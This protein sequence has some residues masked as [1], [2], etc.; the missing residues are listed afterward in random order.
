M[1]R[2]RQADGQAGIQDDRFRHQCGVEDDHLAALF[3]VGD[4]A[5]APHFRAG[6]SGGRHRDHWCDTRCI[7]PAPIVA[8]ILEV[9]D[10]PGLT[11]HQGNDLAAIE[12][13]T[14]AKCDH[15]VML[16]VAEGRNTRSHVGCRWVGLHTIEQGRVQ[17][18]IAK[19]GEGRL[20]HLEGAEARIGDKKRPVYPIAAAKIRQLGNPP[21][22]ESHRGRIGPIR[23]KLGHR[24]APST[25]TLAGV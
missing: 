25:S 19:G 16:P 24:H 5:G 6:A 7:G 15:A 8:N 1:I 22:P 17:T 20:A 2:G 3:F 11:L 13:R 18:A 10:R 4:E 12:G 9:A 21:R 23:L 14:A